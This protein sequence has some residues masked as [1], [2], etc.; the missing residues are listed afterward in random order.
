MIFDRY[1][2]L[3]RKWHSEFWTT[4]YYVTTV[5]DITFVKLK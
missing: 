1:P 3:K 4:G 5:G 2:E